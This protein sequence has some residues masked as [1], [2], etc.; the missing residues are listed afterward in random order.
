MSSSPHIFTG[1]WINHS[2]SAL[3][4][5]TLTLNNRDS[6]FLLAFLAIVVTTAGNSFWIIVAYIIHQARSK[7]IT[8]DGIFYQHQAVLKNSTSALDA[9]WKFTLISLAWRRHERTKWWQFWRSR[10]FAFVVLAL[11]L[12]GGFGV[13]GIFSSQVTKAASSEVLIQSEFCGKWTYSD[14]AKFQLKVLDAASTAANYARNCYG[15]VNASVTECGTYVVPQIPRT[16]DGNASCPF[17]TGNCFWSDTAAYQMSTGPMD[18]HDILGLN[19]GQSER[20]TLSK[21]ATCAPVHLR[22]YLQLLNITNNVPNGN[23]GSTPSKDT[24]LRLFVGGSSSTDWS[25]QYNTHAQTA[26]IGYELV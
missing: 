16:R 4:G 21:Q 12:A 25:Y 26:N 1:P 8:R 13:A 14:V 24:Y 17:V 9:A 23:G 18:S 20:I 5:A 2:H 19:A 7:R 15:D 3:I 11:F 22:P 10:T 6:A